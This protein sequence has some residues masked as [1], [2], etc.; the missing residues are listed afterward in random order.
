MDINSERS[1]WKI[2]LA[3]AATAILLISLFYTGY[4]AQRLREGERN[5]ALLLFNAYRDIFGSE[6]VQAENPEL[7]QDLEKDLSL[8]LSI[9]E[10]NK[11]IPIIV[12]NEAGEV[13]YAT[14]FGE[15]LDT[16][17]TFLQQKLVSLKN[18]GPEPTPIPGTDQ[19]LFYENSRLHQLLT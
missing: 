9:L 15:E 5:K 14:N 3:L 19:Y 13:L 2:Y 1:H 6:D 16:N 18:K 4:L 12:A 11:D 17:A 10:A 7:G 8:P